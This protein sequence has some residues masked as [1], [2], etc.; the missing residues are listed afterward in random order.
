WAWAARFVV[1]LAVLLAP[2]PWLADS[3]TA[4]YGA[5]ANIFLAAADHGARYSFRFWPPANVRAQGS[6]LAVLRVEDH[7]LDK[8]AHMKLDVRAFSYRTMATYLAVVLSAG[9]RGRKRLAY[10]LI[11]GLAVV[12]LVSAV[13]AVVAGFRF[14]IGRVLG[15]GTSPFI[16]TA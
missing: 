15:F 10:V 9:L 5:V 7:R 1:L 16:E 2:L 12:W 8:S 4:A 11:A 6:W 14:G 3:Y 13:L